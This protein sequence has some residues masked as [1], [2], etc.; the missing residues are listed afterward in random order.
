MLTSLKI[1]KLCTAMHNQIFDIRYK[2]MIELH[3]ITEN[4]IPIPV[5]IDLVYAASKQYPNPI[6]EQD[7]PSFCI[8]SFVNRYPN[9]TIIE[10]ILECFS[11]FSSRAKEVALETLV[12]I[13]EYKGIPAFLKLVSICEDEQVT[14]PF[15]LLEELDDIAHHIF[16]QLLKEIDEGEKGV[17]ILAL[18]LQLLLHKKYILTP[19][20]QAMLQHILPSKA[21]SVYKDY[22]S[23][24]KEYYIDKVYQQWNEMYLPIR[25]ELSIYC[26]I[27]GF[28]CDTYTRELLENFLS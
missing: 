18:L 12:K 11:D 28:L 6:D 22:Q 10:P 21:Q 4:K 9:E 2:A 16:P 23:F 27:M 5:L 1:K 15:W 25:S 14:I 7:D 8:L 13:D 19:S 17:H 26:G 3:D 20:D 24:E